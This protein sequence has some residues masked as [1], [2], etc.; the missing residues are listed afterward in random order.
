MTEAGELDPTISKFVLE[1]F[2]AIVKDQQY[3][4]KSLCVDFSHVLARYSDYL[5]DD[6]DSLAD[7]LLNQAVKYEN[8]D[9]TEE[10]N[11]PD[12]FE[13]LEEI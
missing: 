10:L 9:K 5:F 1:D 2:D 12:D 7:I 11:P 13:D 3:L 6:T 8:P 4:Y